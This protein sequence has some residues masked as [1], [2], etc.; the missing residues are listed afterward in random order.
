[1]TIKQ[2]TL[3]KIILNS[4]YD[5]ICSEWTEAEAN[6]TIDSIEDKLNIV[7]VGDD[8][9]AKRSKDDMQMTMMKNNSSRLAPVDNAQMDN[10]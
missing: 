2:E 1:M 6:D 4:G 5:E 9:E 7:T 8:R 10:E 3:V